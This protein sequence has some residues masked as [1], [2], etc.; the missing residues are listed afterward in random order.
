MEPVAVATTAGPRRSR[1]RAIA[2]LTGPAYFWLA[3]TIFLPL[4]AMF[5]FSF[6]SAGISTAAAIRVNNDLRVSRGLL[7]FRHS[8]VLMSGE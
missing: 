7:H 4:S 6:L 1:L 3:L 8:F 5:Y 2:G